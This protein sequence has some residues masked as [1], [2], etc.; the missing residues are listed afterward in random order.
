MEKAYSTNDEEYK[1]RDTDGVFD[2]LDSEGRLVEGAI[3]YE[4]DVEPVVLSAYL[5]ASRILETAEEMLGDEIGEAAEDAFCVPQEAVQELDDLLNAWV[6]KH[7]KG[8]YWQGV[9]KARELKVTAADVA[10]FA[11]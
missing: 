11:T 2:E 7:I 5:R 1:H 9:G 3:Y 8:A 10:S 4:I 6:S